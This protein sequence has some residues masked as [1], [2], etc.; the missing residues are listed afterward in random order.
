[1]RSSRTNAEN[2]GYLQLIKWTINSALKRQYSPKSISWFFLLLLWYTI[3]YYLCMLDR[4]PK[5]SN[6][7]Y[8]LSKF[9][10]DL[11]ILLIRFIMKTN[12]L[13]FKYFCSSTIRLCNTWTSRSSDTRWIFSKKL[14]RLIC[15]YT[16]SL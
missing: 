3:S 15:L 6:I 12:P 16:F 1:M 11:F 10:S 4:W 7:F 5:I 2:H 9:N 13:I 14:M 8:R